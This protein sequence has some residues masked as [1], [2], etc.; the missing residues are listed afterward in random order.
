[1]KVTTIT[2]AFTRGSEK[3]SKEPTPETLMM[4][5][6]LIPDPNSRLALCRHVMARRMSPPETFPSV[7]NA[8]SQWG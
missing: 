7:F 4:F 3:Q 8:C 6:L 2:A 1:M 5:S